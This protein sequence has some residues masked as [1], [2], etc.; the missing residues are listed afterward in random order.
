MEKPDGE[1]LS[2]RD[3]GRLGERL[4]AR[5]LTREGWKVLWRNYRAK[6]GGEVDLIC[7]HGEV[8]V[9][10]EVKTRTSDYFG[11]PADA[12]NLE[13]QRLVIRGAQSWLRHLDHPD[14]LFRFD[15]LEVLLQ[16]GKPPRVNWIENAFQLPGNSI[17]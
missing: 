15:I 1:R 3:I 9:F 13:K 10:V 16:E 8:L 14:L 11:H 4:A 12:V 7:R 5:W 2:N 6:H 17:L